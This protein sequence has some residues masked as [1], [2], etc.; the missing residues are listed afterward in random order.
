MAIYVMILN[1]KHN[2]TNIVKMG[3]FSTVI[4]TDNL[5]FQVNQSLAL[6]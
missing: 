4:I 2:T 3:V 6:Y 5:K 1:N